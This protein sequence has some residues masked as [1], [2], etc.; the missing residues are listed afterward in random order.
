MIGDVGTISSHGG[1]GN[2]DPSQTGSAGGANWRDEL[3]AQLLSANRQKARWLLLHRIEQGNRCHYCGLNFAD[4]EGEPAYRPTLDHVVPR[5]AGGEHSFANTVAACWLCNT[6]KRATMPQHLAVQLGH[7]R[8]ALRIQLKITER[9]Q[10][11]AAA[12][13]AASLAAKE[14][15][16]LSAAAPTLPEE[17]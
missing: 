4:V 11:K 2:L 16:V 17:T 1:S 3:R 5:K 7:R 9:K 14:I 8:I 12:R 10:L 15:G 6:A 13:A